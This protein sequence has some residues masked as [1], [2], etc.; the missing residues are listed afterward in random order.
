[1]TSRPAKKCRLFS[2]VLVAILFFFQAP[3]S[4]STISFEEYRL[5]LDQAL[6]SVKSGQGA[7]KPEEVTGSKGLFP[8]G[9]HV[10]TGKGAE[11]KLNR[12][13]LIRRMEEAGRSSEAREALARHIEAVIRQ[14]DR[15]RAILPWAD[16]Q[17]EQSRTK[18]H[19]I[20]QLNEFQGLRERQAPRWLASLIELFEKLKRWLGAAFKAIEG[21]VPGQ[22]VAYVLYGFLLPAAGFVVFWI[23]RNFGPAGWRRRGPSART[24]TSAKPV[25]ADWRGW[26]QKAMEKAS[27]GAFREAIRFFFVSVLLEGHHHGWW[28]YNPE[29]TNREHLARVGGPME[30]RDAL[31]RLIALYERVWYG[32]EAAGPESFRH[33][34]EWLKRMEA[35]L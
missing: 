30:R 26:R 18:L 4:A 28:T 5:R 22:W 32:Q 15:D 7:M 12:E 13:D 14:M 16:E 23:I 10:R 2:L 19:A 17:W 33:C 35:A 8:T 31:N 25:E 27:G 1:M 3:A 24:I 6:E 9:L 21:K 20:Y 11:V 34:S 29:A